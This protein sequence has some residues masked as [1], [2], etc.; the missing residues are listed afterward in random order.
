[1]GLTHYAS[2]ATEDPTEVLC[3]M[4]GLSPDKIWVMR[5]ELGRTCAKL[6][7]AEFLLRESD[8]WFKAFCNRLSLVCDRLTVVRDSARATGHG[9]KMKWI[10]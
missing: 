9:S 5:D 4:A 7:T 1:M 2:G 3:A 8:L 10:R 6:M